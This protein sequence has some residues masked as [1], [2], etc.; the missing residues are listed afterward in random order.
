MIIEHQPILGVITAKREE[1]D[2]RFT[3]LKNYNGL[4]AL[5]WAISDKLL[6]E[7][8]IYYLRITR[9]D[10]L[11]WSERELFPHLPEKY[12]IML[13]NSLNYSWLYHADPTKR[14]ELDFNRGQIIR[15][16]AIQP[17]T[18]RTLTR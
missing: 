3:G 10:K 11:P 6:S 2:K 13:I 12:P 15:L 7:Q 1:H 4:K 14:I 5:M 16:E 18:L 17:K 9:L 8:A